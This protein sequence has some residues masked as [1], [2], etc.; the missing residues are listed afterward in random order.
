MSCLAA[1]ALINITPL[2]LPGLMTQDAVYL[3]S[4][5]QM[6]GSLIV[7]ITHHHQFQAGAV[8]CAPDNRRG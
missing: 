8:I 1:E 6:A 7:P 2:C 4:C 5:E 3:I